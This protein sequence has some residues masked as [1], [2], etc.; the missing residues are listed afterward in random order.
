MSMPTFSDDDDSD[1]DERPPCL[2]EDK[3]FIIS[4]RPDYEHRSMLV[5]IKDICGNLV[6]MA[7]TVFELCFNEIKISSGC[8][9]RYF[10]S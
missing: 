1:E 5:R 8:G 7:P 2:P 3:I 4:Y 10:F 9:A 6:W